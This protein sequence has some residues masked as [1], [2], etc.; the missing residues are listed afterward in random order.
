[1]KVVKRVESEQRRDANSKLQVPFTLLDSSRDI[2]AALAATALISIAALL[3]SGSESTLS[4]NLDLRFSP[5]PLICPGSISKKMNVIHELCLVVMN[6]RL[7]NILRIL[8]DCFIIVLPL[9]L[10]FSFRKMEREVCY[11]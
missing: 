8:I 7:F 3:G 6:T 10:L 4:S 11:A 5:T 1:M 2:S 9:F